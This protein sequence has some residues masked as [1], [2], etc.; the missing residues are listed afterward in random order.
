MKFQFVKKCRKAYSLIKNRSSIV[1]GASYYPD[2]KRKS[3][4][5]ILKDQLYFVRKYGDY[6]PFYFTYGFDRVEMTRDRMTSEYLIPYNSFQAKINHLNNHNPNFMY[7]SRVITADKFYFNVFLERFGIPTPPLYCYI[8]DKR[9]LYCDPQFGIDAQQDTVQQLKQ[10]FSRDLDAFCKP[11]SGQLGN[12]IFALKVQDSKIYADGEL[13]DMD[14]LI[15]ILLSANYLVQKR[16]Y[17]HPIMNTLCDST[18][19]SIRLQTVMTKD[20]EVIP[21]GAGLRMGRKG[22]SVDNW[23][24]GGVFVGID[25]EKGTL[26]ET[27]FLKPKYGTSIKEHPDTHVVFKGFEVPFYKEAEK[28]AVELHKRLYRCHSVG[29]DIGLTAEGPMFIEGNGL[30]EISLIQAAHGGLKKQ[31][32][33]YF[34]M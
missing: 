30:W 14:K 8:K 15:E 26:M 23:A 3:K 2:Y 1:N 25:M 5:H 6:E 28:M 16:I 32:E 20:G 21:F 9:V 4:N 18:I 12:G 7:T 27:G 29:W 33:N 24:K 17:Q 34:V 19:N 31:I 10:L 22:S 11:S 13:M